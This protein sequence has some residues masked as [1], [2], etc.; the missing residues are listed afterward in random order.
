[1]FITADFD[2]GNIEVIKQESQ[3]ADLKIRHDRNSKYCQWFYFKCVAGRQTDCCFRILNAEKSSYPKGWK[4]YKAV[5]SYDRKEWF[6]IPTDFEN[7]ILSFRLTQDYPVA[8]YATF[9][10]YT[11]DH[12]A[13]CLSRFQNHP[14]AR[15]EVLGTTHDGHPIELLRL[16]APDKNF[17]FW[18]TA[19]QHPGEPMASW[20]M[21]G[22]LEALCS[23]Q[24]ERL[25]DQAVF[26][27]MP[28]MNPDGVARGHIRTNALGI[29]LNKSWL[30]CTPERSPEVFYVRERMHETGVD[31]FLDIHGDEELPYVFLS[32]P[33][34]VPSF[35]PKQKQLIERYQNAL[36]KQNPDF[37][38]EHGYPIDP[39]GTA[40][41]NIASKYIA[42]T[43]GC[44][45][46]TLEQPFKDSLLNPDEKYGWC[47]TRSKKLGADQ[48]Y[49]FQYLMLDR[50]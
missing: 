50:G 1:M 37:Q 17:V 45:S 12:H 43:F 9:A 4:N 39:P 29:D 14:L 11:L 36:L 16:G 5:A 42:E 6:R 49:A 40:D 48:L 22:L 13:E 15:I 3:A 2:G 34:G 31:C 32:R 20:C 33:D 35:T 47:P 46:L 19:R 10:P 30:G 26:Y 41:L 25:L 38:T 27:M 21:D 24:G 28:L 23:S 8:Y 44:L 18:I 7:G